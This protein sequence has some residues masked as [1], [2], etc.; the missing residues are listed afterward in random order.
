MAL[1]DIW[2]QSDFESPAWRA[3][4]NKRY[5]YASGTARP[6]PFSPA[7]CSVWYGRCS[8]RAALPGA[9]RTT[10]SR[11]SSSSSRASPRRCV[12][13]SDRHRP[14]PDVLP[15]DGRSEGIPGAGGG[16]RLGPLRCRH[17]QLLRPDPPS[18]APLRYK[19]SFFLS[20]LCLILLPHTG[21]VLQAIT[22]FEPEVVKIEDLVLNHYMCVAP[23]KG[24]GYWIYDDL[25]RLGN[26]QGGFVPKTAACHERN[27]RTFFRHVPLAVYRRV[28]RLH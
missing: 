6:E 15:A 9:A 24:R 20:R 22:T 7:F 10:P 12:S 8:K 16:G 21:Y 25:L 1:Y 2:L 19:S 17:Q 5:R 18:P 13:S 27:L 4:L 28:C 3:D 23:V 11:P 26:Y 14:R